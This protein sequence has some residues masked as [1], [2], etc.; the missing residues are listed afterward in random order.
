METYSDKQQREAFQLLFLERLFKISDP[1][2][3]V[4]KGGVN[5]RLF[6]NSPRYSEDMDL[7]ALGGAVNTLKKNGYKILQDS[8]FRRGLRLFGIE[9]IQLSDLSK[10]KHT[11][12]TQR[13]KLRIV[14]S[15]G[16][17]FPTKIE[18]SRREGGRQQ[19]QGIIIEAIPPEII[20]PYRRLSFPCPHYDA[21]EVIR[22]KILALARRAVSQVRDPFDI[23]I[24]YLG[25]Y[26][27]KDLRFK[28]DKKDLT[29]AIE[30]LETFSYEDYIGHVVEYL[31]EED[32]QKYRSR[33][34]WK[35]I[36][37]TVLMLI[38]SIQ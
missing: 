6:F 12:T 15:I 36:C 4:L 19:K 37:N 26:V 31:E 7:D 1:F 27:T 21:R 25:G 20:R 30:N 35:R 9:D 2:L 16:E 14:N 18:F 13:F 34:E 11:G 28:I 10:S 24:M 38:N 8:S 23:Y 22:Q 32:K 3:Y 17:E 5:L 33:E 29:S